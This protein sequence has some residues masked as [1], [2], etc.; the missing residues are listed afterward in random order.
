[1]IKHFTLLIGVL[2]GINSYAQY[3]ISVKIDGLSCNDELL[4]AN[5]FGNKQYLKDTSECINGTFH[6]R[7]DE[8][9]N[10]GVYL[11]VLPKKNYFERVD[12]K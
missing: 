7:G 10:T 11:V 12:K 9:L 4:L 2:I 6:F 1:M 3:D 8:K 5:H